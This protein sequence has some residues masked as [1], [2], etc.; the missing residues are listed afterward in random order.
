MERVR[1]IEHKWR[2]ILL[3]DFSYCSPDEALNT[4]EEARKI[5]RAQPEATLLILT[6]VTGGQYNMDVIEN[7]KE[8]T[9][10]NTPYVRASAVVGL[11]GLKK[12]VYN[13]VVM[14]SKRKF[15]VF[16]DALSAK[17]WLITQ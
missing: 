5:I 14:F 2:Q 17:D 6:D 7:L 11:D 9:K 10:G 4:M 3:L 12:A 16:K 13:M 8:F 15:P 1:F